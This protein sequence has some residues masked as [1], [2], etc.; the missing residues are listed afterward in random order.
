ML[1]LMEGDQGVAIASLRHRVPLDE[2]AHGCETNVNAD[3]HVSKEDPAGYEVLVSFA[4][5]L[6]HDILVGRVEAQS[7]R[8]ESISH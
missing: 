4:G 8:R 6:P 1:K 5:L 3:H 7:G 2:D